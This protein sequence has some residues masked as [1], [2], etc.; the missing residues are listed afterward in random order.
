MPL[1]QD[2]STAKSLAFSPEVNTR[3]ITLEGDDFNPGGTLTGGSRNRSSSVLARVHELAAAEAELETH[4]AALQ[5]AESTL[6]AM[7]A[8]AKEHHK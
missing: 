4:Q 1:L 3:C 5:Q 6:R 7:A 2:S 8:A